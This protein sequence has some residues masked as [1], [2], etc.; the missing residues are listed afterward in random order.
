MHRH[1]CNC[2]PPLSA[3]ENVHLSPRSEIYVVNLTSGC[4]LST[5]CRERS[6]SAHV[7]SGFWPLKGS[8]WCSDGSQTVAEP[9]LQSIHLH[10]ADTL[11][12]SEFSH[13]HTSRM[14]RSIWSNSVLIPYSHRVYNCRFIRF[15]LISYL[16]I[17]LFAHSKSTS[18]H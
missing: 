12:S 1:G 7:Y 5:N 3:S 8:I 10:A 15:F 16:Q 11:T 4:P 9:R 13:K 2:R 17:I 14:M 6:S 18:I